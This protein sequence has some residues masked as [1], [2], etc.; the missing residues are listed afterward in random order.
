ML[1]GSLMVIWLKNKPAAIVL[2]FLSHYLLDL[3]PHVEYPIQEPAKKFWKTTL[4]DYIKVF[5][6]FCLGLFLIFIFANQPVAYV[7]ALVAIIPDILTILSRLFSNLKSPDA[8]KPLVILKN[9]LDIHDNFHLKRVHFLK[10]KKISNFWRILTQLA[11]FI[12][13]LKLLL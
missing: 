11:V 6:D 12:I 1:V 13:S 4:S 2:A 3:L 5:L 7:C 10:Y 8:P 9:F